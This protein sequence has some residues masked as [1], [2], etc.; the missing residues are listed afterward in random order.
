MTP[1]NSKNILGGRILSRGVGRSADLLSIHYSF[2][3]SIPLWPD[4]GPASLGNI[5]PKRLN[6]VTDA[7]RLTGG[8]RYSH[9]EKHNLNDN[10]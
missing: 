1:P 2:G 4:Y 8:L 5:R 10:R 9:D 6:S 7:L 3:F